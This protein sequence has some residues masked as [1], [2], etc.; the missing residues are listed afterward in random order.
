MKERAY[1]RAG[2]KIRKEKGQST[3]RQWGRYVDANRGKEKQSR[4]LTQRK[5]PGAG[6]KKRET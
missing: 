2:H 5:D 3:N 4:S 1:I 6:E